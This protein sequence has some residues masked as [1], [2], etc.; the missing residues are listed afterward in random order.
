[1]YAPQFFHKSRVP[2]KRICKKHHTYFS[3]LEATYRVWAENPNFHENFF[4]EISE[5]LKNRA[6]ELEVSEPQN[7]QITAFSRF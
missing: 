5:L 3:V 1:M 2:F 4:K 7:W 6:T